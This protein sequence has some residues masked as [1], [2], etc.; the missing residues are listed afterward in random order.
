MKKIFLLLGLAACFTLCSK[1]EAQNTMWIHNSDGTVTEKATSEID[2][3]IFS[4]A[5]NNMLLYK[6]E[7]STA[8]DVSAISYITFTSINTEDENGIY[9]H[10]NGDTALVSTSIESESLTVE[11]DGANVTITSKMKVADLNYYVYGSAT[12]GSLTIKNDKDFN[13]ILSGVSLT[14]QTAVPVK[15]SKEVTC[16]I[17]ISDGKYNEISDTENNAIKPVISTSW[18]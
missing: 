8:I 16:N 15:S 12:D 1:V 11:V 7:T 10:F 17:I 6:D 18:T 9:I 2:K 4:E 14:S 13:L 5:M 3:I